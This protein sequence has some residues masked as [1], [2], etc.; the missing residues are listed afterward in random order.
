MK[1]YC[2]ARVLFKSLAVMATYDRGVIVCVRARG[3]RE[4]PE[5]MLSGKPAQ[6]A[7]KG[8]RLAHAGPNDH[9]C[10]GSEAGEH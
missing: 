1:R 10:A 6:M 8:H 4:V 5:G 2:G 9:R 3:G 7:K